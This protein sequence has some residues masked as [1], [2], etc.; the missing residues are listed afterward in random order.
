MG[1]PGFFA[2]LLKKYKHNI[3]L[4]TLKDIDELYIDMNCL[5]H[6]SCFKILNNYTGNNIIQLEKLMMKE[7]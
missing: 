7:E 2:W 6:P 1:V 5:L 4:N 3:L